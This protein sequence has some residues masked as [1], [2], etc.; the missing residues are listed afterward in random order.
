MVHKRIALIEKL[1][2]FI[3]AFGIVIYFIV[4]FNQWAYPLRRIFTFKGDIESLILISAVL[5]GLSF[6]LQRLLVWQIRSTF[7][8]R[9]GRG[10]APRGRRGR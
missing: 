6:V 1:L 4:I 5:W 3:L 9:A 10:T 7:G 2:F 8:S